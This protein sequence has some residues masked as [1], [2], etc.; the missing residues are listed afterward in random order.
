MRIDIHGVSDS[1]KVCRKSLHIHEVWWADLDD[2]ETLCNRIKF[3]FWALSMWG[4]KR[5]T[6]RRRPGARKEMKRP[7][8]PPF[9]GGEL[10]RCAIVRLRLFGFAVAFL[11]FAT[12][13][14]LIGFLLKRLRLGRL[15]A[16]GVLY[17]YLG[18]IKLY[19]DR[20][21]KHQGPL[22]DIGLP[23][24]V[25]IRRRIVNTMVAMFRE[26][27][28][29]WYV[30]AHSLGTVVALNGLMETAHA[31]PNYLPYSVWNDLQDTKLFA[32]HP[33][34]TPSIKCMW[35]ARPLWIEDDRQVLDRSALFGKL[36]GLVTYGSPLDKYAYLWP[37]IVNINNDKAVFPEDFE[38]INVFDHTDP[39][40]GKLTAYENAMG[41]GKS[42]KNFPYK[43]HW[44]LLWSHVRYL[45]LKRW[46]APPDLFAKRL[47]DWMLDSRI[48]FP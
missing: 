30:L 1:K 11:L 42:P 48:N 40:A 3:W 19:Q 39:V 35:P 14:N 12:T 29:R 2:K 23:R 18:D 15:P 10:A 41:T 44:L 5:F 8:L 6:K 47:L 46:K 31:L 24:R 4:A 34:K 38:W 13:I 9:Q 20:G 16:D 28:A 22:T 36:R 25:A 7:T 45:K 32:N 43:A 17:Q 27:Y 33:C 21:R 37:Q 26:D